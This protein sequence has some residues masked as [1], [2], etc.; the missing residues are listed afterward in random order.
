MG[1][2]GNTGLES[3]LSSTDFITGF[4]PKRIKNGAYEMSLGAE[5][6]QTDSSP[7]SVKQL[8]KD[9]KI[10]IK[11]G[12]FALLLTKEYVRIPED[13]IA[14][15]SI[16]AGV[17]FKGLINVSGFHVDP[18]FEGNLLFSVY[19]AGPTNIILSNN[20]PY[21]PIWLADLNEKQDYKGDHEKQ[22]K[23]PDSPVEA[24]S[25]GEL[26]SPNILSKRIDDDRKAVDKKIDDNNS[27]IDTRI[28]VLEK[29][30]KATN[31]I[32]VT[33]VGVVIAILLKLAFDWYGFSMG[34]N[35]GIDLQKKQFTSDSMINLQL[36]E[37][38]KLL[39]EIDSL[40]QLR[41]KYTNSKNK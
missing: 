8:K 28:S 40:E 31:Y 18:G 4:D 10:E 26:A 38:K 29:D 3:L 1:F 9:E 13:K 37:K 25:Q 21:F 23:I 5:V 16:K 39:I 14:F 36:S 19:N 20:T 22:T 30:Q 12:Q 2:I 15:I 24:L 35:K 34:L 11:P 33:A 41:E 6:F 7:R 17:K 32:S 27:T